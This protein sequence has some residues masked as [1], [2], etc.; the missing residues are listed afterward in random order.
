MSRSTPVDFDLMVFFSFQLL[1]IGYADTLK[2]LDV[3]CDVG[4]SNNFDSLTKL[5]SLQF[6]NYLILPFIFLSI[7]IDFDFSIGYADTLKM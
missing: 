7:L 2:M 6:E 5:L 4:D 3:F 1:T